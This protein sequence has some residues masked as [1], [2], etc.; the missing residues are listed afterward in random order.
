MTDIGDRIK[1]LGAHWL[2][3]GAC[4]IDGRG[5]IQLDGESFYVSRVLWGLTY[6]KLRRGQR[7]RRICAEP[8]C[9]NPACWKEW[10]PGPR[11]KPK[12][13]PPP[14]CQRNHSGEWRANAQG[15]WVCRACVRG[16]SRDRYAKKQSSGGIAL[17]R[18]FRSAR[19]A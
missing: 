2:W 6:K 14:A 19:G 16:Q 3:T 1:E 15:N 12:K 8:L 7:I 5:L 18:T 11:T 4:D 9:V 13:S 17:A 10:R